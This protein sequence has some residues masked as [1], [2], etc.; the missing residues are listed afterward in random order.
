MTTED[1]IATSKVDNF[2]L[3]EKKAEN[4][5]IYSPN[6]LAGSTSVQATGT[7]TAKVK[8]NISYSLA[9]KRAG[10]SIDS[11]GMPIINSGS[12]ANAYNIQLNNIRNVS[13][14]LT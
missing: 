8:K 1:E 9:A 4:T 11:N 6:A 7:T 13:K 2:T 12:A 10:I 3:S 5:G 14:K